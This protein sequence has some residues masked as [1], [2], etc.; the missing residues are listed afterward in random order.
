MKGEYEGYYG[1]MAVQCSPGTKSV[2]QLAT[3]KTWV[4]NLGYATIRIR[5]KFSYYDSSGTLLAGPHPTLF[6]DLVGQATRE[7]GDDSYSITGIPVE[8]SG[9]TIKVRAEVETDGGLTLITADC[10]ALI[11]VAEYIAAEILSISVT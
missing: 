4:K 1:A 3:I 10:P 8:W 5:V 6:Y 2:T 7:F 9:K 11:T